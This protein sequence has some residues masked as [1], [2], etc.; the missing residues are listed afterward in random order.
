M[1]QCNNECLKFYAVL[2][3]TFIHLVYPPVAVCA[4]TQVCCY[5]HRKLF[6]DPESIDC[7]LKMLYKKSEYF[8][9]KKKSKLIG[10]YTKFW[11]LSF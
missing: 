3:P 10:F 11:F 2:G 8:Y 9:H 7:I 1:Q 6:L 4:Y 5:L